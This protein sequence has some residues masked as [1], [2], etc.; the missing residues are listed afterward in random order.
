[1]TRPPDARATRRSRPGTFRSR[2]L[3]PPTAEGRWSVVD[4]A[5]AT[6]TSS[7]E[8]SAA[9]AQQL[10]T[11]HGIVTRETTASEGI[12]GG[13][14]VVYQVLKAMEDSGR[15]RRGY[16]VAGLGG[17]QFAMP[18]ALDQLR[19]MRE[20]P[21]EARAAIVAATD[22]ANPYGSTVKWPNGG[23]AGRG[24]TRTAG[25]LVVLVDGFLAAYL[26]RG[27][28]EL[29]LFAPEA[30]PQRSRL[31]R[32]AARALVEL[33][34]HRGMLIEEIDGTPATSHSAAGLF[35]EA[36]F[37]SSAMGLQLRPMPVRPLGGSKDPPLR[38]ESR[39]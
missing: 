22:P 10:L 8:W 7:T 31:T 13:F 19:S 28:R 16:F 27:E 3:V 5:T 17:A 30:E 37:V 39:S 26:R 25:A 4:K 9:I 34:A 35:I 21:E 32:A 24:P 38:S 23:D 20:Q 33:S 12:A 1:L 6:K 29:L 36:G 2:R 14:S 11:R 15:V 18:A